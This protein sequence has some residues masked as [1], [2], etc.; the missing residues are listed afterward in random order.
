M[1]LEREEELWWGGATDRQTDVDMREKHQSIASHM[2][3]NQG[4]GIPQLGMCPDRG[5]NPQPFG[6]WGNAPTNLA[7]WLGLFSHF[8]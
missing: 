1:I 7:T 2:L 4:L 6:V 8:F 5:S 3:P